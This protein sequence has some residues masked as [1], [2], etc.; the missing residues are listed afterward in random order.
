MEITPLTLRLIQTRKA[1]RRYFFPPV[2]LRQINFITSFISKTFLFLI[3][4][5]I[6][7]A[8]YKASWYGFLNN[9]N[10]AL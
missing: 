1:K 10:F 4:L 5:N 2:L 6:L 3:L 9:T 8:V 7:S